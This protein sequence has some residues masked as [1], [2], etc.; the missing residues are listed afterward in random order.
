MGMKDYI[1]KNFFELLSLLFFAFSMTFLLDS[2]TISIIGICL[3]ISSSSFLFYLSFKKEK[4]RTMEL[5]SMKFLSSFLW[6]VSEGMN[7]NLAYQNSVHFL[8]GFF[9]IID[10]SSIDLEQN[11][12]YSLGRF[13]RF[14]K[15]VLQKDRKSEAL[16]PNYLPLLESLDE[17]IEHLRNHL[18][19]AMHV[20]HT[21]LALMDFSVFAILL[22][23]IFKSENSFRWPTITLQFLIMVFFLLIPSTIE[24]IYLSKLER[25]KKYEE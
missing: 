4:T 5:L 19:Q 9:P 2:L 20:K 23:S 3:A 17:Q 15:V 11:V 6:K 24:M 16:L 14:F 13:E 22:L 25:A 18:N 10:Y 8:M 1:K 7:P 21:A 12:P